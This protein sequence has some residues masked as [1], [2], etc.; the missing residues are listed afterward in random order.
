MLQPMFD[1]VNSAI[2]F[3]PSSLMKNCQLREAI[4]SVIAPTDW[5]H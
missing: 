5:L 2:D 1:Q 3:R 4:Q